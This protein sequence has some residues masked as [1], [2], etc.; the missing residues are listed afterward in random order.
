[1]GMVV[2]FL[3]LELYLKNEVRRRSVSKFTWP[4]CLLEPFLDHHFR[5]DVRSD[6]V[7][8]LHDVRIRNEDVDGT[9]L[10]TMVAKENDKMA[11]VA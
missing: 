4:S 2:K 8:F 3:L 1:M 10:Q 5:D 11:C 7:Q 6:A 9:E